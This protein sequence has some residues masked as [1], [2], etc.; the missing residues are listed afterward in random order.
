MLLY[1][2]KTLKYQSLILE[3]NQY[4]KSD[5]APFIV[6][7]DLK[8]FNRNRLLDVKII[9]AHYLQQKQ[10]N[11]FHQDFQYLQY[12]QFKAQKISMMYTEVKIA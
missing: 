9:L 7:A 12:Q 8:C 2:L 10:V 11:I 6:Y 3:F 5:K 4:Q 1:L